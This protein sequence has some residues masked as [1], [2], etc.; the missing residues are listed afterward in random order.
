M[1]LSWGLAPAGLPRRLT[2]GQV[3]AGALWR[4]GEAAGRPLQTRKDAL[5]KGRAR[6]AQQ[7]WG[8]RAG[9]TASVDRRDYAAGPRSQSAASAFLPSRGADP[10]EALPWWER[11]GDEGLV[12]PPSPPLPLSPNTSLQLR[13][14]GGSDSQGTHLVRSSAARRAGRGLRV[15]R[16]LWGCF[17]YIH[18]L[19]CPEVLS[20]PGHLP[21]TSRVWGPS[22]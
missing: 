13:G 21:L 10:A 18:T 11:C 3:R 14:G 16:R 2:G 5:H 19:V 12:R 17:P 4:G 22:S 7:A 9:G 20:D 15:G 8:I 1:A 6:G